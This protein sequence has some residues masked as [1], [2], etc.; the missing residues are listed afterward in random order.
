MIREGPLLWEKIW[1][2]LEPRC[3]FFPSCSKVSVFSPRMT[4]PSTPFLLF[5]VQFFVFP[6]VAS[7]FTCIFLSFW[8]VCFCSTKGDT[9]LDPISS[10]CFNCKSVSIYLFLFLFFWMLVIRYKGTLRIWGNTES[11]AMLLVNINAHAQA[12]AESLPAELSRV[13]FPRKFQE[14]P[15]T[16]RSDAIIIIT[17]SR[18]CSFHYASMPRQI[19]SRASRSVGASRRLI[20]VCAP[21]ARSARTN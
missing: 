14:N 5:F 19:T 12:S 16:P 9:P 18:L 20:F 3:L 7:P 15:K 1:N 2:P 10:F 4:P 13:D 17:T 6:W 11:T 8:Q 21:S